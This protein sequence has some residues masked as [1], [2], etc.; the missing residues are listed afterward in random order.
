MRFRNPLRDINRYEQKLENVLLYV[1]FMVPFD[2]DQFEFCMGLLKLIAGTKLATPSNEMALRKGL[3][4]FFNAYGILLRNQQEPAPVP[5]LTLLASILEMEIHNSELASAFEI[6]T[7][8]RRP[9]SRRR[10]VYI[11]DGSD[12]PDV[13]GRRSSHRR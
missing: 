12:D 5:P 11:I 3:A 9:V 1:D 10:G 6:W 2:E 7:V 13:D 8:G 4:E